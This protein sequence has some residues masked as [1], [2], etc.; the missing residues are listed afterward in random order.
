M[1]PTPWRDYNF[2]QNIYKT[3]EMHHVLQM[4]RGDFT[5][6]SVIVRDSTWRDAKIFFPN[7][8]TNVNEL[9]K[10]VRINIS[11]YLRKHTCI[12]KFPRTNE[13]KKER[14][15]E[16]KQEERVKGS[17]LLPPLFLPLFLDRANR[18]KSA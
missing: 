8:N 11:D 10:H 17:L 3:K 12:H 9:I 7:I 16:I 2:F 15:E 6:V 1:A 13:R 5:S 14:N 4:S 18:R